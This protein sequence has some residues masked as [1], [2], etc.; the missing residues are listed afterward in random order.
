MGQTPTSMKLA[1]PIRERKSDTQ[2]QCDD[3]R[4]DPRDKKSEKD[5]I[6]EW[7]LGVCDGLRFVFSVRTRLFCVAFA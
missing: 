3:G 5:E 1:L 6:E 2:Q 4:Q 7:E